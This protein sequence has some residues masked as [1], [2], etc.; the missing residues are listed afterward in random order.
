LPGQARSA[1]GAVGA[2]QACPV[3]C[4]SGRRHP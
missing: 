3:T 4:L 2:E 1:A